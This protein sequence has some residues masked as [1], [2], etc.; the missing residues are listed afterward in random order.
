M[1]NT[2]QHIKVTTLT[3]EI[4]GNGFT[5]AN[6]LRNTMSTPTLNSID[7]VLAAK[8]ATIRGTING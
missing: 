6:R 4:I 2:G 5:N 1:L 7:W 3:A 8:F